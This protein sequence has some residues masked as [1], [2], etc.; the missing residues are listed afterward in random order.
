MISTG[1]SSNALSLA[2][3]IGL[4]VL[5][6]WLAVSIAITITRVAAQKRK[7]IGTRFIVSKD[8]P[9][10]HPVALDLEGLT[11]KLESQEAIAA[12]SWAEVVSVKGNRVKITATQAVQQQVA[13]PSEVAEEK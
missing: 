4:C 11:I 7:L 2:L 12:G 1:A 8:I 9:A 5:F 13:Q 3:L 6:I 10:Q